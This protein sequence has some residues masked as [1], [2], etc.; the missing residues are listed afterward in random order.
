MSGPSAE[1]RTLCVETPHITVIVPTFNR[2]SMLRQC[3]DSLLNQTIKPIQIIVVDDGS[4]DATA[5]LAGEFPPVVRYLHKHNEGKGAA[6]NYALPLARGEWI[7]F[8]D[9]DDVAL[10]RSI[11]A[12]LLAIR[13][14]PEASLV[15]SRFLWG[16]NDAAGNIVAGAALLWPEFSA[17]DFYPKF[18][19][20]CFAHLNGALVRRSRIAEVGG[21]RTDLLTSEDYEFTLRVAR[22]QVVAFCDEPT[23]IFR[24]HDGARGPDGR[25]YPADLRLRKFADGDAEIGRSIRS[26]HELAEYL[27][28]PPE[29]Q[30]DESRLQEALLARLEVM[31]AKGLPMELADD[32]YALAGSL[33]RTGAELDERC[34]EAIK[35]AMQ[36]RYLTFRVVGAPG[37][38]YRLL[39]PL[40]ASA[41]GRS[42][43]KVM[44]R[45]I[46]GLAWWQNMELAD[47]VGLAGLALRLRWLAAV[48]WIRQGL[49]AE[50]SART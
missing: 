37:V 3:I 1:A 48:S 47:R 32:A 21:F 24:Q 6:L 49:P 18:L 10:P 16:Q 31:A 27:G 28:L 13:A 26:T 45:A 34:S 29:R 4:T 23:F 20:S 39:S 12:R 17:G 35:R 50:V 2:A 43:L 5:A 30:L 25:Q 14:R 22:G 19:R 38:A 42:M 15:I 7:W 33:D 8:F 44:A 46:L 41:A 36:E 9:D 40:G 11:E